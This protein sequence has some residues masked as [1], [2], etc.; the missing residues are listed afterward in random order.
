[1]SANG[2]GGLFR[3]KPVTIEARR[4]EPNGEAIESVAS[5]CGGSYSFTTSADGVVTYA[6][7]SIETLEGLMRARLGDWIIRGVHGEFDP[8]KPDIFAE[9]YE[10]AAASVLEGV[11][12]GDPWVRVAAEA[13]VEAE[14]D[15][16][17]ANS[18]SVE[19]VEGIISD[20]APL[21][22]G[23]PASSVSEGD[24]QRW[25]RLRELLNETELH[26][27]TGNEIDEAVASLWRQF[28]ELYRELANPV[29][30][31][32]VS[33]GADGPQIIRAQVQE[34]RDRIADET[35]GAAT[36][37][38][39]AFD[40]VL[41]E[42]DKYAPASA[43]SAGEPKPCP[44]CNDTGAVDA[45]DGTFLGA[46]TCPAGEPEGEAAVKV[47]ST[48]ELP[49]MCA[50]GH[51]GEWHDWGAPGDALNGEC[52]RAG[53]GCKSFAEAPPVSVSAGDCQRAGLTG[54]EPVVWAVAIPGEESR[55]RVGFT[56]DGRLFFEWSY[57]GAP[58]IEVPLT[59]DQRAGLASAASSY[60]ESEEGTA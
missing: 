58:S 54:A 47:A 51:D 46:C 39:A 24:G 16:E 23:R 9:T 42:F 59:R 53:C 25:E 15:A 45:M 8:C 29:P 38:R 56:V 30:A 34:W 50:C 12:G 55:G 27:Q 14:I 1:M 4:V 48:A 40:L 60:T 32:A 18:L 33:A 7:I 49:P 11:D 28:D 43:V 17:G 31:S 3:K 57:G 44:H 13:I 20:H 35:E 5:W 21:A 36:I 37:Y 2:N 52:Q 22:M 10:P 26:E 6:H 19:E 41:A